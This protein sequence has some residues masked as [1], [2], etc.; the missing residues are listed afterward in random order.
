MKR[1][2]I[3]LLLAFCLLSLSAELVD[4]IVAKVGSDI[5]LMSDVQKQMLQMRSTGTL[6]EGMTPTLVLQQMIEQKVIYQKAKELNIKVDEARIKSYAERYLRQVKAEYPSEAAFNAELRQM[7]LTQSDLLDFYIS[8]LTEN[9][10]TERLVERFVSSKAVITEAEMRQFY[11]ASKDSLAVKPIT[12]ELGMIMAEISAGKATQNAKLEEIRAI[13]DR[14][15]RGEDFAALARELSDCP[16]ASRGGD[17]NFF[18]RGMM[19]KEFEDAAFNLSVGEVSDIVKTQYGYHLIKV[20]EKRSNEIRASHILKIVAPDQGDSLQARR[21]LEQAREL[22]LSGQKS[23][24]ELAAEYSSDPEASENGG[25]IGEFAADE[26]PELFATQILST[27]VGQITPVLEHEGM[28][29]L[30]VRVNEIPQR[31]YAYDEVKDRVGEYLYRI[32]QMEAYE[33]WIDDLVKEAY[34]QIMIQ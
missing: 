34:V 24:A 21:Q 15:N 1:L 5:I 7:K 10:M 20:M 12:W 26:I 16:S 27:P 4:R 17:L 19:V 30:F 14:L 9:A 3:A 32:K 6:P 23:F 13:R 11:E 2:T 31:V 28:L 29:Y 8:K 22:Y 25:I 33:Q 18:S